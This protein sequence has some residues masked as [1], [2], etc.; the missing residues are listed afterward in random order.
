MQFS[1]HPGNITKWATK[2][3]EFELDFVARHAIKSQ[4]LADFVA[5]WTPPPSHLGELMAVRQ[6][7][8]LWCSPALTGPSSSMAPRVSWGAA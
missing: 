3:V 7:R 4:V 2:L 6:S 8:K 1:L 5:D